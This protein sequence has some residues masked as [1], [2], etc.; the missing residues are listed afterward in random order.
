M[1]LSR[2]KIVAHEVKELP[3]ANAD[4]RRILLSAR[5][6]TATGPVWAHTTHYIYK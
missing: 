2:E 4:E 1:I 5:I 3:N 6:E